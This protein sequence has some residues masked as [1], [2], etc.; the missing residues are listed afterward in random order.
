MA[1]RDDD[2]VFVLEKD[3][4]FAIDKALTSLHV[5]SYWDPASGGP[6]HDLD[7]HAVLLTHRGGDPNN[8]VMYGG[9][10]HFLTYANKTL[11]PVVD[12]DGDGEGFATS[13]G[14]MWRSR[15]NR[16]G[17]DAGGDHGRH[18]DAHDEELSEEM[19]IHLDKLP[20]P[21]AE[22]A[23]WLTIHDAQKRALDFSKIRGLMVEV[24]DADGNELCR[25]HPTG[26]FAGF[27]A[28]QVGSLMKQDDGSWT[29]TAI[30][31]GSSAGLG[32]VINAYQG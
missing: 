2:G 16:R 3:D 1:N 9:G 8:A 17:G 12:E 24:C 32:D 15:D 18:G 23:V 11:V 22:V 30:G 29:F 21:G 31:A 28:L 10:S 5:G 19:M 25:Y 4:V 27:T 20:T 13:D 26:E 7:A 14:S 6:A